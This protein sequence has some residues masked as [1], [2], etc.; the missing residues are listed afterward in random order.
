MKRLGSLS[1]TSAWTF[2]FAASLA[3]WPKVAFFS[4]QEITPFETRISEAG[5]CHFSA[6]AATSI[7]RATAP[8]L[9]S[10]SHELASAVLPPVPCAGPHSRLLYFAA[11]AGAPSTR[12]WLQSASSSSATSVG[13]PVYVPWPISRCFTITVT[14]LSVP[15]R[16]KALGS[17]A[18][19][20]TTL[21]PPWPGPAICAS[22]GTATPRVSP[23]PALRKSRRLRLMIS[24]AF[25]SF[26]DASFQIPRRLP[27]READAIVGSATAYVAAHGAF[28]F[29][30]GGALHL[31]EQRCGAHD[32]ARLAVAALRHV[33]RDPGLLQHSPFLGLADTLDRRDSLA[34]RRAQGRRAG[35]RGLAVQVH[36]AGAAQRHAAAV[37]GAGHAE[38]VAQDPQERR[39]RIGVHRHGFAVDVQGDHRRAPRE[40]T[41][42]ASGPRARRRRLTSVVVRGPRPVGSGHCRRRGNCRPDHG[43]QGRHD[44]WFPWRSADAR[45]RAAG[46]LGDLDRALGGPR[47]LRKAI[48]CKYE[49][50]ERDWQGFH[51]SS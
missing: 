20:A 23:A 35:S 51:L 11:S 22:D 50:D 47:G 33:V 36:R 43:R 14:V 34:G 16:T 27:D 26:S 6:A 10:C 29:G 39:V 40:K 49:Q 25:M 32:L 48:R 37:L 38:V 42:S 5:A 31:G 2:C 44:A 18:P 8:A 46:H 1:F 9:R 30:V 7:A 21:P 15:M 17:R 4:F 41:P 45:R 3:S 12:I 24:N 19:A 13:R 28:D